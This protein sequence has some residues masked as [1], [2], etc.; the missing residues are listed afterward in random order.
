MCK[1][2]SKSISWESR[3]GV[4][5]ERLGKMMALASQLGGGGARP[6]ESPELG[7]PELT[8]LK[9]GFRALPLRKTLFCPEPAGERK[10]E[11][12]VLKR[13]PSTQTQDALQGESGPY[14]EVS[15]PTWGPTLTSP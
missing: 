15:H 13:R 1:G 8:G 2:D 9:Q 14:T 10:Q 12:H 7:A 6:P 4:R 3:S 11:T 5:R